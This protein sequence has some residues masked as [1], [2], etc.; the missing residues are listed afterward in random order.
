M[1]R[2]APR[3]HTHTH[4]QVL[5]REKFQLRTHAG[6]KTNAEKRRTKN[7]LMV[8]K[9]KS[10]QAGMKKRGRP[11]AAPGKQQLKRDKRKRRRL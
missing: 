1:T 2:R 9:K 7:Y 4:A 3:Q 11:G 10:R 8:Q 6:G 5:A